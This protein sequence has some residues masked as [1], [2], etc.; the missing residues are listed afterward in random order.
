MVRGI[1]YFCCSD[2]NGKKEESLYFAEYN[3]IKKLS[4][5][6]SETG[7]FSASSSDIKTLFAEKDDENENNFFGIDIVF[8]FLYVA[9]AKQSS[10][11]KF[12]IVEENENRVTSAKKICSYF[13]DDLN[14][15]QQQQQQNQHPLTIPAD[16]KVVDDFLFVS[17][18]FENKIAQF[19]LEKEEEEK[20][21]GII[22][23][24]LKTYE[25]DHQPIGFDTIEIGKNK[26]KFLYVADKKNV[27]MFKIF[28][29]EDT[30][31]IKGQQPL[32]TFPITDDVDVDVTGIASHYD[33]SEEIVKIYLLDQT[34]SK[35]LTFSHKISDHEHPVAE[36]IQNITQAYGGF[37]ISNDN[38]NNKDDSTPFLLAKRTKPSFCLFVLSNTD[39]HVFDQNGLVP[40]QSSSLLQTADE[41]PQLPLQV[42][43]GA[44]K[45]NK[46][47]QNT[48]D[49]F[50]TH[51]KVLL[52]CFLV[53]FFI[54]FF[55]FCC[56][57]R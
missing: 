1:T 23:K 8:P 51:L 38:N 20:E 53:L 36:S 5:G 49:G 22:V 42:S 57:S 44:T 19:S 9:N 45:R 24:L 50:S 27:K 15:G 18:P 52:V 2:E 16:I 21:N 11:D 3:R 31:E 55:L 41:A 4:L 48:N 56:S 33:P 26:N 10:I 28:S 17:F 12:T 25:V 47:L 14:D 35:V 6:S 34:Y 46:R 54:Y 7:S 39:F 32:Y 30:E 43:S 40:I 29:S 13:W 37:V